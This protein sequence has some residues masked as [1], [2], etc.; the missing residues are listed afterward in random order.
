M[1]IA[2]VYSLPTRRAIASPF[3]ATDEDTKVSALAIEKELISK[4]AD[5]TLVPISEDSISDVAT[6]RADCLFNL[7]EWSGLDTA[8]AIKAFGALEKLAIPMTGSSAATFALVANKVHMKKM[9]RDAGL[10]TPRWQLFEG[11]TE[12]IDP[13]LRFPVIVKP[14]YEHCSIGLTYESI[15]ESSYELLPIVTA[16]LVQHNQPVFAEEF[17]IGREFQTTVLERRGGQVVLPPAEII[18]E[19]KR[20]R[21]FL[22]Y[23]SRW[24][25]DHPEY[26]TSSVELARLSP[27]L[28][29]ALAKISNKA[30]TVLGFADY[31]RLDI[32]T[33]GDDVF[34]LEANPNPG[35][36]DNEDYGMS[37]SFHAAGMTFADFLW[38]IVTS[39][40]RRSRRR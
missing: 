30:F 36:E 29:Q 22:T 27:E 4:G 7:I 8:L 15:A 12:P 38:E 25:E 11:G 5:V 13:A 37:V 3:V 16:Q 21:A 31:S 6:I 26:E 40:L 39:C 10:L 20:T 28:E 2:I 9:L 32:R 24:I 34:L 19:E 1:K 14:I 35:L 17:I 18:F 33:R 23:A